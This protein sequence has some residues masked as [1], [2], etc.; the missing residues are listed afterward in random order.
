MCACFCIFQWN[1]LY[2]DDPN[3]SRLFFF[4]S[5]NLEMAYSKL[6]HKPHL[7]H[8]KNYLCSMLYKVFTII[9]VIY[10]VY[11]HT[12]LLTWSVVRKVFEGYCL[13]KCLVAA[14][15]IYYILYFIL[16]WP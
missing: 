9:S 13:C 12:N 11:V 2:Y 8:S 5:K 3:S 16:Y 10:T 4:R 14:L 6:R 1:A 15:V 7:G